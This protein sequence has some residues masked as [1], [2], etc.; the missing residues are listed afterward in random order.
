MLQ[1]GRLYLIMVLIGLVI[2]LPVC[3][4][5]PLIDYDDS[6]YLP[7]IQNVKTLDEYQGLREQG[8]ILDVLPVRDLSYWLDYK[9]LAATGIHIF[10]FNN[11]LIWLLMCFFFLRLLEIQDVGKQ[12]T[13][14]A[15]LLFSAHPLF[16]NSV[17]WISAR[18]HLLSALFILVATFLTLREKKE[19]S[20]RD[21]KT[22]FRII[23][24]YCL[25]GFSQPINCLWPAWYFSETYQE[26]KRRWVFPGLAL[27]ALCIFIL[28]VN[29]FYYAHATP[30][31]A[32]KFSSQVVSFKQL[33]AIGRYYFQVIVPLWPV[34]SDHSPT[35]W[36]N[37]TGLALLV[38]SLAALFIFL[39]RDLR[40]WNW[41]LLMFL[42]MAIVHSRV[43]NIFASDTYA[44]IFASAF[45]LV[46]ANILKL[47]PLKT[48]RNI[49]KVAAVF[50]CFL[51]CTELIISVRQARAWQ[52]NF[53]LWERAYQAEP[54]P[55]NTIAY[56]LELLKKGEPK[57]ALELGMEAYQLQP[58]KK[59][60]PFLISKA[61]YNLPDL[62]LEQKI[63]ALQKFDFKDP[64]FSYYKAALLFQTN[65][66]GNAFQELLPWT[67]DPAALRKQMGQD[68][69]IAFAESQ[70]YCVKAKIKSA[71]CTD[72]TINAKQK[73]KDWSQS[74][75]EKRTRDLGL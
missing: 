20:R 41:V 56:G 23:L 38:I 71:K 59:R 28:F 34:V 73:L 72:A 58:G 27:L 42:P 6:N 11:L 70:F 61:I 32:Q 39:K 7:P 13:F 10:H 46:M 24:L 68:T 57:R 31:D 30:E 25:S 51:F 17:P 60:L 74:R 8:R 52:S 64:W 47:A 22:S 40:I 36:Q 44:L 4:K 50:V 55:F 26:R 66:A 29:W 35:A 9:F 69:E 5:S 75:F 2:Y 15:A 18:K 48:T 62:S 3:F 63:E 54:T 65:S 16:V 33:T 43:T 12:T 19:K 21:V 14:W 53:S 1:G 45:F 67:L 49:Q 37:A